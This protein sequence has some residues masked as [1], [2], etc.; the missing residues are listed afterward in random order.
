[1]P[2]QETCSQKQAFKNRRLN[3]ERLL[4]NANNRRDPGGSVK[5]LDAMQEFGQ[6][7]TSMALREFVYRETSEFEV[8]R[9]TTGR[10][11]T[12]EM[13]VGVIGKQEKLEKRNQRRIV[14]RKCFVSPRNGIGRVIVIGNTSGVDQ[15]EGEGKQ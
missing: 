7:T 13:F 5:K 1:M 3:Q 8:I 4:P 15:A 12:R 6:K 2:Y 9:M 10:E 14:K 11:M